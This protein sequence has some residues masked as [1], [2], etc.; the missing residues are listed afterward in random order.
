[1]QC[2]IR[3]HACN[4]KIFA[5]IRRSTHFNHEREEDSQLKWLSRS[6]FLIVS[7]CMHACCYVW[8]VQLSTSGSTS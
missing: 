4:Y 8:T 1:M 7:N 3:E 2:C 6:P 5:K